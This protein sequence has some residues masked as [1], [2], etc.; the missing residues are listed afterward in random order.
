LC[1]F[2]KLEFA[3]RLLK[4]KKKK[5]IQVGAPTPMAPNLIHV[6]FHAI[7]FLELQKFMQ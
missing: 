5:D 1:K 4:K 3:C 6:E 7:S 2:T